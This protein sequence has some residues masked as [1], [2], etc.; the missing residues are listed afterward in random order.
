[1][2]REKSLQWKM[3]PMSFFRVQRILNHI[4]INYESLE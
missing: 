1:M 2:Q 3:V 4:N